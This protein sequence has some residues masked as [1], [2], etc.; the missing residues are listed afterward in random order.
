MFI[1]KVRPIEQEIDEYDLKNFSVAA[2]AKE[3]KLPRANFLHV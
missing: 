3:L 2:F 1:M